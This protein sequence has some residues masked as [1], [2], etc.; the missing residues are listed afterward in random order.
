MIAKGVTA[1]EIREKAGS[2]GMRTLRY[3]ALLKASRG[4]TSIDEVLRETAG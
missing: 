1:S 2:L 3:A 4:E